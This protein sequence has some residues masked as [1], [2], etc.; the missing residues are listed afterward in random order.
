MVGKYVL[1]RVAIA[2][3]AHSLYCDKDKQLAS[4]V[5]R[6][7]R[8]REK[9]IARLET[10]VA[11]RARV[12]RS[13]FAQLDQLLAMR[14]STLEGLIG[15]AE[16]AELM[17]HA[18]DTLRLQM[19]CAEETTEAT[20][21]DNAERLQLAIASL[22]ATMLDVQ[23]IRTF[24]LAQITTR[25]RRTMHAHRLSP[26]SG[27]AAA[28]FA[29]AARRS[30]SNFGFRA[31]SIARRASVMAS[32][33]LRPRASILVKVTAALGVVESIL[34]SLWLEKLMAV[35]VLGNYAVYLAALYVGSTNRWLGYVRCPS[36]RADIEMRRVGRPAAPHP[37][38]P[39][40][41]TRFGLFVCGTV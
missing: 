23:H 13:R 7:K 18:A 30:D 15:K 26:S 2:I 34:R 36:T 12:L 24:E 4:I 40:R 25:L 32:T 29:V 3:M 28:A 14:R 6:R 8:Q 38:R 31:V 9:A 33:T 19:L 20:E 5:R 11:S 41:G 35:L 1:L 22:T 21:Q 27:S 39:W 10:T 16:C 37:E 17:A